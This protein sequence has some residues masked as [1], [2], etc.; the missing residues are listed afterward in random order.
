MDIL[1]KFLVPLHILILLLT[2]LF[3]GQYQFHLKYRHPKDV[4]LNLSLNGQAVWMYE[5]ILI[6]YYLLCHN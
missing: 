5:A 3:D 2:N 6:T 1:R 4:Y